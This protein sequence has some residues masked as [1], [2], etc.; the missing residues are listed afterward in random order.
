MLWQ[1]Q[2]Y[3]PVYP[4]LNSTQIHS[5]TLAAA[6]YP[7]FL[8]AWRPNTQQILHQGQPSNHQFEANLTYVNPRSP[9]ISYMETSQ[10][11]PIVGRQ[12]EAL[13]PPPPT[14]QAITPKSEP[15]LE[16][17]LNPHTTNHRHDIANHRR[18][19]TRAP[20]KKKKKDHYRLIIN[21][22]V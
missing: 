8:P 17:Q 14:A 9:H 13:P 5:S 22:A 18:L 10:P 6:Y 21:V 16:N 4:G 3:C 11:S 1:Q 15:I 19:V 20:N 7:Y 2:H 12:L